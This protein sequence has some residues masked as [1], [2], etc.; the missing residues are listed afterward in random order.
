MFTPRHWVVRTFCFN[1]NTARTDGLYGL[2]DLYD[3]FPLY[4]LDVSR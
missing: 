2:Y 1:Q 4:D 3:L